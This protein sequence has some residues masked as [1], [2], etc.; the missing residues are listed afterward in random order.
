[1]GSAPPN[2]PVYN[3]PPFEPGQHEAKQEKS[4]LFNSFCCCLKRTSTTNHHNASAPEGHLE[5]YYA[6]S[7][8]YWQGETAQQQPIAMVARRQAPPQQ[9][10]RSSSSFDQTQIASWRAHEKSYHTAAHTLLDARKRVKDISRGEVSTKPPSR[11]VIVSGHNTQI[12]TESTQGGTP[13]RYQRSRPPH[14]RDHARLPN[15]ARRAHED[16][17]SNFEKLNLSLAMSFNPPSRWS[18]TSQQHPLE[19]QTSGFHEEATSH[20]TDEEFVSPLGSESTP[21]C[22]ALPVPPMS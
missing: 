4:G 5:G 14:R 6:G 16:R 8:V 11:G 12:P 2:R 3:K 13:G 17:S 9:D 7:G 15:H 19:I 21:T 10:T 20:K 22:S 18:E 1:M